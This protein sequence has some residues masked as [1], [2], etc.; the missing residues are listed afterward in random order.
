MLVF[1]RIVKQARLTYTWNF[2]YVMTDKRFLIMEI[3]L[4]HEF[5]GGRVVIWEDD[6]CKMGE[7]KT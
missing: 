5:N 4:L 2:T 1:F 6:T 3:K 7:R